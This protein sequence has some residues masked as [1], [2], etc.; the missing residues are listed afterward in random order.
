FVDL[1]AWIP[2]A[3]AG[4]VIAISGPSMLIA[5]LKLRQRSLG[6]ILDA[7]GWA[8]NGR[9]KV[10]VRLGASLSKVAHV[11]AQARRMTRDP[12][13]E[14][15]GFAGAAATVAAVLAVAVLAW[16]MGWLKDNLPTALQHAPVTS[17]AVPG[18]PG[19]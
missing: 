10:N 11:P 9:M 7:S 13:A 17:Q 5:W 19:S 2:M 3:V 15:S 8:I 18:A 6:P 12:Y 4:I 14:R 16:R 1:G